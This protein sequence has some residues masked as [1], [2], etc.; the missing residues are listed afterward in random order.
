MHRRMRACVRACVSPKDTHHN[1]RVP[2]ACHA[3][4]PCHAQR[5]GLLTYTSVT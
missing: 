2:C 5:A 4:L 1:L 3:P